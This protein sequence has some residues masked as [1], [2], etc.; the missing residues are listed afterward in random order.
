MF[1]GLDNAVD[2]LFPEE[3]A[4]LIGIP[5]VS[6]GPQ[7]EPIPG[8][9]FQSDLLHSGLEGFKCIKLIPDGFGYLTGLVGSD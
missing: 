2:A 5:K 3:Q 4:H 7:L 9:E 8:R 1:N 6:V